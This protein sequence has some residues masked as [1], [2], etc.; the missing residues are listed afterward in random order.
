MAR[1][2]VCL[3]RPGPIDWSTY[4]RESMYMRVR[5]WP[6]LAVYNRSTPACRP[7]CVYQ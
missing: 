2:F 7:V 6:P 5:P 4:V 3:G 1:T